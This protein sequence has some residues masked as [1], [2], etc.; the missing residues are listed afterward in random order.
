[1]NIKRLLRKFKRSRYL[2]RS[3]WMDEPTEVRIS[4]WGSSSKEKDKRLTK[5]PIDIFEEIISEEPKINL[6]GPV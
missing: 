1:M 3:L 2:F 5:K 4:S 6:N